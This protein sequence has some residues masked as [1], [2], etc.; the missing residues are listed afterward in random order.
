MLVGRTERARLKAK[1]ALLCSCSFAMSHYRRAVKN[2]AAALAIVLL[3]VANERLSQPPAGGTLQSV[4]A[5]IAKLKVC[6]CLL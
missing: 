6:K 5:L 3:R 4:Q 1:L 2:I